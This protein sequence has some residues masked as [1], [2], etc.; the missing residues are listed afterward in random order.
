ML[1]RDFSNQSL[2]A[3]NAVT[4]IYST[5]ELDWVV[6]QTT[7][8]WAGTLTFQSSLDGVNFLGLAGLPLTATAVGTYAL[9][10][11]TNDIMKF[12]NLGKYMRIQ[13]TAW[14]SGTANIMV[15]GFRIAK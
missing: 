11:T 9:S 12:N 5:D 7:G 1:V 4:S 3:V 10:R 15:A 13:M 6:V 14:T 8:T 2:G